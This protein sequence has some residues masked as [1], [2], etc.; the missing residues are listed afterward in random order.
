MTAI[1]TGSGRSAHG[2][3]EATALLAQH[4]DEARIIAGGTA[5]VIML[6]NRLIAPSAVISLGNLDELRYIAHDPDG[7]LRIGAMTTLRE[8]ELSA[9][10]RSMPVA[11]SA[12]H[13]ATLPLSGPIGRVN[14][15]L[16]YFIRTGS[17]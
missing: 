11:M 2:A 1:A 13:L 9:V 5:V 12:N 8:V 17:L 14:L 15:T 4:G 7:S 3:F 6:K 16:E 10:V